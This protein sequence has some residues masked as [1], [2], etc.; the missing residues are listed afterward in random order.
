ML[1]VLI[2]FLLMKTQQFIFYVELCVFKWDASCTDF[3]P[4]NEKTTI[5]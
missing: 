4:F 5:Q 2:S 3:I 1:R